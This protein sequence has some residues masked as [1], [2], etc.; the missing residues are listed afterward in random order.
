MAIPSRKRLVIHAGMHKTGSTSIQAALAKNKMRGVHVLKLIKPNHSLANVLLFEDKPETYFAFRKQGATAEDMAAQRHQL[1]RRLNRQLRRRA[2]ETFVFSAERISSAAD[3]AIKRMHAKFEPIFSNLDVYAYVRAPDAFLASM[4][5]QSAKTGSDKFQLTWPQYRK[6][7][8]RLDRIFGR[9]H[10][11]LRLFDKSRFHGGDVVS[12]FAQ[13][14]DLP[15]TNKMDMQRNSS[16]S[17]AGFALIACLRRNHVQEAKSKESALREQQVV[18]ALRHLESVPFA[19]CPDL[20]A[21]EIEKQADDLAWMEDR[22]GEALPIGST[23]HSEDAVLISSSDDLKCAAAQ[24]SHLLTD[25]NLGAIPTDP[26]EADAF[27]WGHLHTF[28]K[29]LPSQQQTESQS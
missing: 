1:K 26:D 18:Q 16:V 23:S 5:Q 21:R 13:W 28:I 22:L 6:R 19:L 7:F 15:L 2:E 10:V 3:K 11:N 20:V 25:E 9:E 17:A 4:M 8:E 24:F 29:Q 14:T 12:D 27:A